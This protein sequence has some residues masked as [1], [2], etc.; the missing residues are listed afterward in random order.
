MA[1]VTIFAITDAIASGGMS[2][3]CV[4]LLLQSL[5]SLFSDRLGHNFSCQFVSTHFNEI[6][7]PCR[8]QKIPSPHPS[9]VDLT[10]DTELHKEIKWGVFLVRYTQFRDVLFQSVTKKSRYNVGTNIF[11]EGKWIPMRCLYLWSPQFMFTEWKRMRKSVE[12][13]KLHVSE[14]LT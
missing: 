6:T 5:L 14:D 4:T 7:R 13:G 11:L 2:N 12:D 9:A 3:V 8:W 10:S 1:S